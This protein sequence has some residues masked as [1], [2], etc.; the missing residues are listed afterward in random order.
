MN[1]LR[2]GD[3]AWLIELADNAAARRLA[4]QLE[5]HGFEDVVPGDRTVLVIGDLDPSSLSDPGDA[6][7]EP[8]AGRLLEIPVTYDGP[9]LEEAARL[10]GIGVDELVARHTG[11]EYV[12]AFLGFAGLPYLVGGDPALAV[13]RRSDPRV[14]VPAG[15]VGIAGPYSGIYPRESPGGWRLIGRTEVE[16]FDVERRPPAVLAPGDRVRFVAR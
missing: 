9:D 11:P 12:V 10:A 5:G 1:V 4:R 8:A 16:L 13:P 2:A 15:S 7:D 3:R 14:R 6:L